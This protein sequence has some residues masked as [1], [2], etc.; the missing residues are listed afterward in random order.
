MFK[1][2][3]VFFISLFIINLAVAQ[4]YQQTRVL[5][6]KDVQ[7]GA[8]Q[9]S[10]YL[11]L[12]KGKRVAVIA[13]A[14]SLINKT[15]LVDTLLALKINIKKI[16]SPEHGFRGT[17]DAG[18]TVHSDKDKKTGVTIISLY[19]KHMKPTQEDLADVDVIVYDIQDVG[20]RFYTYI[21]TMSNCMDAAAEFKKT[22][23]VLDR[24]NPNGYY[25]DGPVLDPAFK[26][27]LGMHQVPLVYG[28]TC[29]EY[30]QMVNGEGWLSNKLNCDLK[31]ISVKNYTHFDMYQ[32]P[33][34]PSPNLPNMKAVYLYP[35]LGLFEGTIMSVGR[36][37]DF[38]FQVVG[39]PDLKNG[40]FTFTPH[41]TDGAKNP[42]YNGVECHGHDL[43]AF[44]DNY[45][46]DYRQ[47]YLLWLTGTY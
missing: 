18:E 29:G 24:P 19:G 11:P 21:S 10:Q 7:T 15:H 33:V 36:G 4:P 32:L 3:F 12:L 30:A 8:A 23:I 22:F 5:Y 26:S 16:F 6:E 25:V 41:P 39:H 2:L 14:T 35:S 37:T 9:T 28:M 17:A 38:P 46:K 20:V 27:F 31:V 47:V 42:K 13:N 43:R 44:A 34:K 1:R 40:D 45:I